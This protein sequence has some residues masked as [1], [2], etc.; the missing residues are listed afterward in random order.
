MPVPIPSLFAAV[1]TNPEGFM[2]SV[3]RRQILL[4]ILG[5]ASA[6][7][8]SS[9]CLADDAL[10][11]SLALQRR[12]GKVK[13][14]G[15]TIA[16]EDYGSTDREAVLMIMGNGTQL[17]AWPSELIDELLRRGYRVVIYDNRDVGLSTKFDEAGVPDAKE[18]IEAQIAGKPS[19][20]PYSL[21]DMAN[22]AVGLLDGLGIA[23]AHIVGVSMG[24]M[25]AQLVAADHPEHTLSLTSI[26]STSG[27]PEV[28][29]PAKPEAV[30]KM[31]KPAPEGDEEAIVANAVKTVEILAG[32]VY[33][34]DE[35]RIRALITRSLKRSADRAGMARHNSLSAIGLF[36]D[37]RPKL[38]TIRVPTVVVHGTEDPLMSVEGA[39]DT[40][41]NIPGAE[42]RI[43]PGMG[44]DLPIPLAKTIADAIEAAATGATGAK[45]P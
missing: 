18:V 32:P 44:H 9:V 1:S 40:A 43:I 30:S 2:R 16:Y 4:A 21:D 13:A 7:A 23:R 6:L 5:V 37:R 38:K 41:A 34:P 29:F 39:K 15:I 33:P 10:T 36:V 20:L 26:M 42:L 28:P 35:K 25:I 12:E 24:G 14:N 8:S 17:T 45:T 31:P 22:D 27:N 19:P 3:S 11:R